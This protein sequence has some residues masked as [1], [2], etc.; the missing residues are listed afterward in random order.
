MS[1]S[2]RDKRLIKRI[3]FTKLL[4][5]LH[6]SSKAN[7]VTVW[8]TGVSGTETIQTHTTDKAGDLDTDITTSALLYC[9]TYTKEAVSLQVFFMVRHPPLGLDLLIVEISRSHSD[10]PHS[11]GSSERVIVPLQKHLPWPH[12]TPAGGRNPCLQSQQA[13]DR[14][15]RLRQRDNRDG[16]VLTQ[17]KNWSFGA[18]C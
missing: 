6:F 12:S 15:P 9:G 11:V 4:W 10:T 7:S 5:A 16:H 14:N 8:N 2:F 17:T 3:P 13:N 1:Y 18:E